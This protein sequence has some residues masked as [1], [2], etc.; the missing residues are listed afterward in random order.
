[1]S[2]IMSKVKDRE[3][4]FRNHNVDL[5][6]YLD[7]LIRS[8]VFS[9]IVETSNPNIVAKCCYGTNSPRNYDKSIV[10]IKKEIQTYKVLQSYDYVSKM[11]GFHYFSKQKVFCLLLERLVPLQHAIETK[12]C[13]KS[14]SEICLDLIKILEMMYTEKLIHNDIQPNNIMYNPCTNKITIIDFGMTY[15]YDY[16][17]TKT[18]FKGNICF[19]SIKG[20][21]SVHTRN[22]FDDLES[23]MYCMYR[24]ILRKRLPWENERDLRNIYKQK[25]NI[26]R[27]NL[28][29]N[30]L[31]ISLQQSM[32]SLHIYITKSEYRKLTDPDFEY[33]K[34]IFE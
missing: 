18:S 20:H 9:V 14:K 29:S 16:M 5:K 10:T 21:T 11:I 6:V 17:Q 7:R 32:Y 31:S 24:F 27:E 8:T 25:K 12:L 2:E 26:P 13:E 30:I 34:S 3:I 23:M 28:F 22:Y 4:H 15:S 1:M 33:L 19:C